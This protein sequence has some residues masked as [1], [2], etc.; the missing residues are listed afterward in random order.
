[1]RQLICEK[2]QTLLKFVR[3]MF[4]ALTESM[5]RR[6]L[7]QKDLRVNGVKVG[8]DCA[9]LPG[10]T[11]AVYIDDRFLF[12]SV[13]V[14][15]EDEHILVADKPGGISVQG[16]GGVVTLLSN[17]QKSPVYPVHRLDVLT[18]GIL[19]LAKNRADE[20]ALL[21]VFRDRELEKQYQ[22]IVVGKPPKQKDMVETYLLKDA[23]TAKVRVCAPNAPGA[24]LSRTGY[25]VLAQQRD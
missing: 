16:E 25:Q 20:A 17:R 19:V 7:R 12:P 18:R 4:P 15:Y 24:K 9:L 10:D 11:V 13:P 22:C 3:S 23:K 2:N 21:D 14:L 5:L 6:A 1:M 8:Q